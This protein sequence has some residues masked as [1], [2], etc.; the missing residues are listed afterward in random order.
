MTGKPSQYQTYMSVKI[1][2]IGVAFMA[3]LV[4]SARG[5]PTEGSDDD[6]N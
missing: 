4:A 6:R 5:Q 1:A 2:L 3:L